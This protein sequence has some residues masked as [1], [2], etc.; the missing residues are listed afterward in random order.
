MNDIGKIYL[1]DF[2]N[3]ITDLPTEFV[4]KFLLHSQAPLNEF[5]ALLEASILS[6]YRLLFPNS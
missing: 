6:L 4:G 1:K 3:L 2:N 5:I